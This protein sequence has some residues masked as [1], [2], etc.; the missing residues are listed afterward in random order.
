MELESPTTTTGHNMLLTPAKRAGYQYLNFEHQTRLRVGTA[1]L[2]HRTTFRRRN[3]K[4]AT[5]QQVSLQC[6][7]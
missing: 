7:V 2:R 3:Q 6:Q 5:G 1:D 4:A